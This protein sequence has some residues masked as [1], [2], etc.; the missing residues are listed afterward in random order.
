MNIRFEQNDK[1]E[2]QLLK[3]RRLAEQVDRLAKEPPPLISAPDGFGRVKR[4]YVDPATDEL[5][6]VTDNGA[7]RR[8]AAV[9]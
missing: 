6:V 8:Y 5:V 1:P 9:P 4:I 2:V 7:E 3:L